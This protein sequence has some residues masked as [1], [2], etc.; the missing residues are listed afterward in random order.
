MH[1]ITGPEVITKHCH[2]YRYTC[3]L[4]ICSKIRHVIG[5]II[6]TSYASETIVTVL[7]CSHFLLCIQNE[8]LVV[9]QVAL[10]V[11]TS[12]AQQCLPEYRNR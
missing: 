11:I 6:A 4:M 9:I 2:R 3:H 7:T 10:C 1:E 8:P 5:P 12:L